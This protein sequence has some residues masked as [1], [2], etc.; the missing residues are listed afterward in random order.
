M[1]PE[2]ELPLDGAPEEPR[3]VG[4]ERIRE[5]R[6][7]GLREAPPPALNFEEDEREL[8]TRRREPREDDLN[9]LRLL[10]IFHYVV[11]GLALLFYSIPI[12]HLIIGIGLV[13]RS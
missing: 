13:R 2:A 9:H 5:A 4:E 3:R 1:P 12:V 7:G 6:D 8:K 11:G 10:S